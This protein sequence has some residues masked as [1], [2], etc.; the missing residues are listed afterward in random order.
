MRLI[1]PRRGPNA[2]I[3]FM[4][5]NYTV[6]HQNIPNVVDDLSAPVQ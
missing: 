1:T 2:G 5:L 3:A 4:D 6:I